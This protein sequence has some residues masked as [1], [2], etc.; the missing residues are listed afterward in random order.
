MNVHLRLPEQVSF[1]QSDKYQPEPE[2]GRWDNTWHLTASTTQPSPATQ[3]L[4]VLMPHRIGKE[5]ALPKV[6]LVRGQGALGVKLTF[7]DGA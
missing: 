6:E 7:S 3:F 2:Q 4:A 5:E 1:S